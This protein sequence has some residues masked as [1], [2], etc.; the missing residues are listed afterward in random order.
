MAGRNAG[1]LL[2]MDADYLLM[3]IHDKAAAAVSAQIVDSR[4]EVDELGPE[5][6]PAGYPLD[7]DCRGDDKRDA[8]NPAGGAR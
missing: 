5:D 3:L 6:P 2:A 1:Y 4:A 8:P 7:D